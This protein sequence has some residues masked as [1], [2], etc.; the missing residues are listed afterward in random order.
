[1]KEKVIVIKLI[2]SVHNNY[3]GPALSVIPCIK[4]EYIKSNIEGKT[5]IPDDLIFLTKEDK[6]LIKNDNMLWELKEIEK[7][8]YNII[9]KKIL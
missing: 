8:S 5:Q 4:Y 6:D 2:E 1:M 7:R 3:L 9:T